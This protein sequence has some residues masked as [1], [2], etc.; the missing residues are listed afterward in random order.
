MD[1]FQPSDQSLTRDP[2]LAEAANLLDIADMID[3]TSYEIV[4]DIFSTIVTVEA[5]EDEV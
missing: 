3:K 4:G 1:I 5:L 2:E